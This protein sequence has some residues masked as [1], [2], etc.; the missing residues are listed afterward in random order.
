MNKPDYHILSNQ[1]AVE[2]GDQFECLGKTTQV[3][4]N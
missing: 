4:S 3:S 1:M 2:F